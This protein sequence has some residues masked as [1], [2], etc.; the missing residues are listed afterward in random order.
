MKTL[1]RLALA[2]V[3]V[4]AGLSAQAQEEF[5]VLPVEIFACNFVGTSDM[6]DL[7]AAFDDFNAWADSNGIDDLTIYLLTPNF[8]SVDFEFDLIGLNI[9]P[10]GAAFGSGNASM[11]GDPDALAS[12]EGV[13]DCAAHSLYALVGVKPPMQDPQSGG[14]FEFTD[15]TMQGNRSTDEGIAAVA[16]ASE[17]F[18]QWNLNDAHAAMFNIAGLPLDTSYQF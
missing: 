4:T 3:F 6:N 17:L 13:V 10:D 11:A 5:P 15:C 12:F 9:W 8:F 18:S 7:N 16:A 1:A 2:F 14:L